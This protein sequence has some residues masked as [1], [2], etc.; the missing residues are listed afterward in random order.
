MSESKEKNN[1]KEIVS[2]LE[3][4]IV[5][6]EENN[7]ILQ[8]KIIEN[9]ELLQ[10]LKK[11]LNNLKNQ[12]NDCQNTKCVINSTESEG[13]NNLISNEKF[14]ND[15]K[16]LNKSEKLTK[17]DSFNDINNF[18]F[19]SINQ[20]LNKEMKN[21]L[22]NN[23]LKNEVDLNSMGGF[24][25]K[26]INDENKQIKNK[27]NKQLQKISNKEKKYIIKKANVL[28]KIGKI[29]RFSHEMGIYIFQLLLEIFKDKIGIHSSLEE[30]VRLYFST[31][32]KKSLNENIY[33]KI[34]KIENIKYQINNLIKFE[35]K[36]EKDFIYDLFIDLSKLY[37]HCYLTDIIVQIIYANKDELFDWDTMVDDLTGMVDKKKVLFTYL[38]GLCVN[39]Q[40]FD[41]S[42]IY[43]VAYSIEN[44][45]KFDI[46]QFE[47]KKIEAKIKI[48]VNKIINKIDN[49]EIKF[50]K[51][52]DK[53]EKNIFLVK[54]EINLGIKIPKWDSIKYKFILLDCNNFNWEGIEQTFQTETNYGKCKLQIFINNNLSGE[55]DFILDLS[56]KN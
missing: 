49:I 27:F 1:I 23:I 19:I 55:K 45:K 26:A 38:P 53:F 18:N 34:I 12:S 50:K 41:D 9:N 51:I 54:F 30:K 42:L 15:N 6:V 37:F 11:E 32:I 43:V 21:L 13:N 29:V 17:K 31:W 36:N 39:D 52:P 44:P 2:F 5:K 25:R 40:F 48:P 47:F 22:E 16:N 28:K 14:S 20:E 4:I 46:E 10:E 56:K 8:T 33:K 3:C 24:D 35:N 7:E